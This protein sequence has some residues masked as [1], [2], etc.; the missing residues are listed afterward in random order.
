MSAVTA[1]PIPNVTARHTGT[2]LPTPTRSHILLSP[3][4]YRIATAAIGS[5]ASRAL[6]ARSG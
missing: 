2:S 3:I 6:I 5:S 1:I 4:P